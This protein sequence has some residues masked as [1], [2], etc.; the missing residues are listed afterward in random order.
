MAPGSN[1]TVR[2]SQ[3]A[4]VVGGNSVYVIPPAPPITDKSRALHPDEHSAQDLD[5]LIYAL[6]TG[7][8]YTASDTSQPLDREAETM[9][10]APNK[11]EMR[12][13][14]IADTHL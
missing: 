11:Y 1:L 9:D 10:G 14:A 8:G 5:E 2:R 13:I 7:A 3:A 12:R 4:P 6:K